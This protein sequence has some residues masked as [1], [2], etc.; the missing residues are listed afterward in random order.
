[1]TSKMASIYDIVGKLAP[2]IIELKAD[3][4]DV[5]VATTTVSWDEPI[6]QEL[7]RKWVKNFL[8]LWKKMKLSKLSGPFSL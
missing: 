2:I 6:S 3:L 5:V 1:M 8:K 4:R 7:R